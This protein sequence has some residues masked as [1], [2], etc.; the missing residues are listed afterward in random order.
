[1]RWFAKIS[2]NGSLYHGWQSQIGSNSV[3]ETIQNY[4]SILL[5]DSIEIV[6]CGRTDAGVHASEYY[7]HFDFNRDF[8]ENFL[9]RINKMLPKDIVIHNIFQVDSKAHA[10]FDAL[11][12]TYHY[13]LTFVKN[14]FGLDSLAFIPSPEKPDIEKMNLAA[15]LIKS[16]EDFFP[17]SKS[18]SDVKTYQCKIKK[19]A[20]NKTSDGLIFEITS[21][22]FLRGMV[23]LI[24]GACLQVGWGKLSLEEVKKCMDLQMRIP[25]PLSVPPSGLFLSSIKYPYPLITLIE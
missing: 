7:F 2:Y 25:K 24:V 21:D 3:Q 5:R 14:P 16:Y 17:F 13:H 11:Q 8:P 18:K 12:R 6:G 23:R 20:W 10:R 4:L 22:R 19:A 9:F 15:D 1:M